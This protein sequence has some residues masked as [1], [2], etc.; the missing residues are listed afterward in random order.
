[1]N[2]DP[3][4]VQIQDAFEGG[5]EKF[6]DHLERQRKCVNALVRAHDNGDGTNTVR[7]AGSLQGLPAVLRV[8]AEGTWEL[9]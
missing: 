8:R 1:M 4:L 3:D 7:V 6:V 2:K 9:L 5:S